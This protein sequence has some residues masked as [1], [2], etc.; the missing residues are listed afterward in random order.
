[1]KTR[2]LLADDHSIM[3]QGLHSLLDRES[4]LEI[5]GEASNGHEAIRMA[6]DLRP[7]VMV[8]DVGMPELSGVEATER[9][10]SEM[11]EIRIVALSMHSDRRF[12][13]GML[14]AGASGYVLK[15]EALEELVGA[16]RSVRADRVYTSPKVTDVVMQDYVS[17][18]NRP[19]GSESSPLTRRESQVLGLLAQG[20]STRQIAE[21]LNLS[22]NTIDTHRRRI[23][24]KLDLHSIAELTKYA[25][26]EG[27]TSVDD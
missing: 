17:K 9:I 7:D 4:D 3:R 12:V 22:V 5:V 6:R 11:P 26:R 14:S 24:L 25:I 1:M 8:M 27:I 20:N 23:M 10:K 15:S 2:I 16:I 21:Q 19:A 13:T 18:L